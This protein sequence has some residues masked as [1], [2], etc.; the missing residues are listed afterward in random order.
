MKEPRHNSRPTE[1][2]PERDMRDYTVAEEVTY[3]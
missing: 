3:E 2:F 1:S